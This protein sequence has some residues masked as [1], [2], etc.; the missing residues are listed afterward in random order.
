LGNNL[1]KSKQTCSAKVGVGGDGRSIVVA[2]VVRLVTVGLA[3][4][5]QGGRNGSAEEE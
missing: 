1:I 2:S 5:G 4:D 3:S